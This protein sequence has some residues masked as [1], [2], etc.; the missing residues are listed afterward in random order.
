MPEEVTLTGTEVHK[1]HSDLIDQSYLINVAL[2]PGYDPDGEAYPVVIVTDGGPGFVALHAVAPLM[3]MSGELTSFILVGISYD[4]PVP[5]YSMSLRQRDLTQCEG[6]ISLGEEMPD[7]YK[8]LPAVEPGGAEDFLAFINNQV[9]PLIQQNYHADENDTTYAGYSLG[10]LF[11]LFALFNQPSSFQRYVIGSPSIWWSD[12]DI[13]AHEK[14][15]A[16]SHNDLNATVFMSSGQ[17]EEPENLNEAFAMVTNM[18][19]LAHTLGERNY[20]GLIIDHQVI[21]DETHMSGHPLALLRGLRKV[22]QG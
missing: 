6:S 2:P 19:N 14:R 17:L 5:I 10:G 7:W 12:K 20:P 18:E 21:A 4:V 22:F 3:Q 16:A 1:L 8:S 15:Y 9:K 11:G 13:L